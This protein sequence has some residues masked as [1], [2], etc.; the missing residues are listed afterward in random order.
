MKTIIQLCITIIVIC[1]FLTIMSIGI[2]RQIKH[3]CMVWEEQA[4]LYPNFYYTPLQAKQC[5]IYEKE[6]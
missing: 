1:L 3:E 6:I 5:N 4:K 2:E